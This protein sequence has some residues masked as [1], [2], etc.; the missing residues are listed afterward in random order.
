MSR[1]TVPTSRQLFFFS[2][3]L[4][5]ACD[6][7][8][9]S[10]DHLATSLAAL[11]PCPVQGSG[12]AG[13]SAFG[14]QCTES[15]TACNGDSNMT[16]V[17]AT[18][19]P[20]GVTYRYALCALGTKSVSHFDVQLDLGACYSGP[21]SDLFVDCRTLAPRGGESC[22]LV[23]PDPQTLLVGI[24]LEDVELVPGECE[25]FEFTLRGP[26][27][28]PGFATG[29]DLGVGV[30]LA[31]SKSTN[32]SITRA[33]RP[34]PGYACPRGPACISTEEDVVATDDH[35]EV[36]ED[37]RL[38]VPAPGVGVN[39]RAPSGQTLTFV[40]LETTRTGT[41]SFSLELSSF[42]FDPNPDFFGITTFA[43]IARSNT[44][45][46]SDPATV[47][48]SVLPVPDAPRASPDRRT[49]FEDQVLRLA[50]PG[51]LANDVDPDGAGE[52]LEVVLVEPPTHG[53]AT[54]PSDGALEYVPDADFNGFDQLIYRVRDST[55]QL[56]DPAILTIEI[57]PVN[58]LPVC[59]NRTYQT[60][61]DTLLEVPEP[62]GLTSGLSDPDG[63]TAAVLLT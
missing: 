17:S 18:P 47:T 37:T 48:I 53:T 24:K 16:L 41:L 61:E 56:S 29:T 43:Y 44:G 49:I 31:A 15:S 62:L 9:P 35:Y 20:N 28:L 63:P 1:R 36:A 14:E 2:S 3:A 34:S 39:D 57:L 13:V 25:S 52:P 55:G 32:Q 10:P 27:Q 58:D 51:L 22:G 59:A 45:L 42:V 21:L 60:L 5:L 33:N 23:N 50:S 40:L 4:V 19:T 6:T 26:A 7:A 38:I 8:T 30:G 46:E 11:N 54:V 12:Q